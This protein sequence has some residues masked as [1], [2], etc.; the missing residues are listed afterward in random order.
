MKLGATQLRYSEY[1]GVTWVEWQGVNEGAMF[2]SEHG[3]K[4]GQWKLPVGFNDHF[5]EVNNSNNSKTDT[6]TN[7]NSIDLGPKSMNV[8]NSNAVAFSP[9][10]DRSSPLTKLISRTSRHQNN[11]NIPLNQETSRSPIKIQ[12]NDSS[13]QEERVKLEYRHLR[14]K[15]VEAEVVMEF[16]DLKKRTEEAK[17]RWRK[18][19]GPKNLTEATEIGSSPN[20][21]VIYHFI[22]LNFV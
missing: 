2:Y 20:K 19:V 17:L 15:D 8:M 3:E 21:K 10:K 11:D 22:I 5:N 16:A 13:D 18:Y 7:D 14:A 1:D 6:G 9:L 4:G 12:T